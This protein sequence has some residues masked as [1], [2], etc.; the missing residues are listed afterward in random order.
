L[1]IAGVVPSIKDGIARAAVAIDQQDA[2]RTLERLVSLS[3][4]NEQS[5]GAGA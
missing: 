3:A 5:A 1:F 4:V 2:R